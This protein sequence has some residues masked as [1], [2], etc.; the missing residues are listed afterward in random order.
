MIIKTPELRKMLNDPQCEEKALIRMMIACNE[1]RGVRLTEQEVADIIHMDD[2]LHQRIYNEMDRLKNQQQAG[3]NAVKSCYP[4]STSTCDNPKCTC[5][6][7]LRDAKEALKQ[8]G[9]EK[10]GGDGQ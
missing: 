2:A 10:G 1:I 4:F 3:T 8:P 7:E 9:T 5:R 6:E